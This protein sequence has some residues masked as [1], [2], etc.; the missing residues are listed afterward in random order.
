M[1]SDSLHVVPRRFAVRLELLEIGAKVVEVYLRCPDHRTNLKIE[2]MVYLKVK[3][4]AHK[5]GKNSDSGP[6]S[7]PVDVVRAD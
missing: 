2:N 7:P 5:A 3:L 6:P 1:L 4:Q